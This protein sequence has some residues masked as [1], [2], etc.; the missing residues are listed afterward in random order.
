M[1]SLVVSLCGVACLSM[2]LLEGLPLPEQLHNKIKKTIQEML[3]ISAV[4]KDLIYLSTVI[5]A[6]SYIKIVC[7]KY[8]T[9]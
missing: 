7:V 1:I 9:V 6:I 5:A 3:F 2:V 4:Y 8:T